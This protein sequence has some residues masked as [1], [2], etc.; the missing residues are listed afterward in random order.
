PS[1]APPPQDRVI[2]VNNE[3]PAVIMPA[4]GTFTDGELLNQTF[5]ILVAIAVR[6]G[7]E[8]RQ[9]SDANDDHS[10]RGVDGLG[11]VEHGLVEVLLCVGVRILR[12]SPPAGLGREISVHPTIL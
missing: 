11:A 12:R 10:L 6:H 3:A 2:G 1:F 4:R 5:E 8:T 7:N 9:S